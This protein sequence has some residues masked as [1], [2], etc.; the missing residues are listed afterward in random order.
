MDR[1]RR[2]RFAPTG[3]GMP[4]NGPEIGATRSA[5]LDHVRR[6]PHALRG[7]EAR[8]ANAETVRPCM[9]ALMPVGFRQ[10]CGAAPDH[11]RPNPIP[12]IRACGT[13]PRLPLGSGPCR[14]LLE[15]ARCLYRPWR[16]C[17]CGCRAKRQGR[18]GMHAVC[19]H[20]GRRRI[21]RNPVRRWPE[22]TAGLM[23][24]MPS[25]CLQA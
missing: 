17:F 16:M 19:G 15:S 18:P 3:M 11:A 13:G 21:F 20:V 24:G 6:T 22:G 12:V 10:A 14:P 9:V 25:K 4:V 23:P 7:R 2:M 1:R 8:P 5:R